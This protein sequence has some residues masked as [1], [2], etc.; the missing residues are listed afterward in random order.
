MAS[1][2]F[3]QATASASRPPLLLLNGWT[4]T[5]SQ[6]GSLL[7][8]H[9]P[10]S[11]YGRTVIALDNRGVGDG[12]PVRDD[13]PLTLESLAEDAV[14]ALDALECETAHV[15]GLSMGGMIAQIVAARHPE[16]VASL[17]LCA[18]TGGGRQLSVPA[19]RSF[20]RQFFG[21]FRGV[22]DG[23]DAAQIAAATAFWRSGLA[24]DDPQQRDASAARDAA[25]AFVDA[26]PRTAAGT[27]AQLAALSSG[28]R[29]VFMG[30]G[31]A[32]PPTL[33]VHGTHDRVLPF[34]NAQRL[35]AHLGSEVARLLVLE[36][37]G[38]LVNYSHTHLGVAVARF[39]NSVDAGEGAGREGEEW[40]A[41]NH[42]R[43]QSSAS[44]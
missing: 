36:G 43:G 14:A 15:L 16:R 13:T 28:G 11:W 30:E 9:N 20:A 26:G 10:S 42:S 2:I 21:T 33:I 12:E 29:D 39:L 17:V 41:W 8:A 7:P 31:V 4:L 27:A 24:A 1:H 25:R 32:A 22:Q 34:E 44:R 19:E 37:H 40:G 18:T 5:R 35:H 3:R 23:D 38:H 6:W